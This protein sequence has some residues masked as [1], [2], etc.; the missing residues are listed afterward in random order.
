MARA[1]PR[2][3]AARVRRSEKLDGRSNALA[4]GFVKPCFEKIQN[5]PPIV[6]RRRAIAAPFR[7][8]VVP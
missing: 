6:R 1:R 3:T 7:H 8:R 5:G 4:A 2:R